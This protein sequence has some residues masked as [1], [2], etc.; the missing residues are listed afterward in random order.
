MD[1]HIYTNLEVFTAPQIL[2]V[3]SKLFYNN[4]LT[5]RAVFPMTG[6][7]DI[8]AIKFIGVNG[9]EAQDE[10]SPSYYNHHESIQIVVQV[11]LSH[12]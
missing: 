3:P 12:A 1:I 10:D 5:C 8:P 2:E 9:H 11:C 7:K 4:K 6:P